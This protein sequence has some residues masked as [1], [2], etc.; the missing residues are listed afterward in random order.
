MNTDDAPDTRHV[1]ITGT[2]SGLGY[3]FVETFLD[4]GWV[5]FAGYIEPDS[6]ILAKASDACIPVRLDV[7][8]PG[9][10]REAGDAVAAHTDRLDMLINNAGIHTGARQPLEDVDC[11]A[12]GRV[13]DVNAIGPLRVTQRFLGLL[14]NGALKRIVNVSSEAGSIA[15]CKRRAGFGY[16]MS[17]AALNMQT[18]ILHNYLS[19]SGFSVH[20]IHPGGMRTRMGSPEM[21]F[22]P[23]ESAEALFR[24]ITGPDAAEMPR[25]FQYDGRALPW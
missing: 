3:A 19:P 22:S 20:A 6:P 23:E 1:V 7:T 9:C 25:F 2:D 8:D 11:D 10:I 14:K 15:D 18:Q 21:G 17:K 4:D 12:I 24:L 13:F 16:N 5:V